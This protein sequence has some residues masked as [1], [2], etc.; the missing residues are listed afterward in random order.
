[1]CQRQ[2]VNW[3]IADQFAA[4]EKSIIVASGLLIAGCQQQTT[5]I[6]SKVDQSHQKESLEVSQSRS[7]D[8][9]LV[10]Y[11]EAKNCFIDTMMNSMN[12]ESSGEFKVNKVLADAFME[13]VVKAGGQIGRNKESVMEEL[14]ST[15]AESAEKTSNM[16]E[17][18]KQGYVKATHSHALD[19]L[20][21]KKAALQ[22]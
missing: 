13:D 8:A 22:G 5:D 10:I 15:V 3:K 6:P 9:G 16:T 21:N 4:M 1:M 11:L 14:R 19:C 2:V 12:Q 7:S 18:D 20:R 17:A